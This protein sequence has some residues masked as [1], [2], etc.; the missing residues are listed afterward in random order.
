LKYSPINKIN[1]LKRN[2]IQLQ[3]FTNFVQS[4]HATKYLKALDSFITSIAA[5]RHKTSF[6]KLE[7]L[8]IASIRKWI[9][10]VNSY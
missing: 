1:K 7:K 4:A 6:E 10:G 9:N 3:S 5:I 8:I 2:M